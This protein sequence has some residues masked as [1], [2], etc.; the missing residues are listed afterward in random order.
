MVKG[1]KITIGLIRLNKICYNRLK[2]QLA[3]INKE[4]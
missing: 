4:N 1:L 3:M 2:P